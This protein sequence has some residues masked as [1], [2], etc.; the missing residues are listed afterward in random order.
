MRRLTHGDDRSPVAGHCR[1]CAPRMDYTGSVVDSFR[2]PTSRY[3]RCMRRRLRSAARAC[4][5]VIV[6]STALVHAAGDVRAE[7]TSDALARIRRDIATTQRDADRLTREYADSETRLGALDD[8]IAT[9]NRLVRDLEQQAQRWTSA[10]RLR[11]AELY[12]SG[13]RVS[14]EQ[15][16]DVT[17]TADAERAAVFGSSIAQRDQ[18]LIDRAVAT[19]RDLAAR[20]SSL[21]RARR[22]VASTTAA[23]ARA[24]ATLDGKLRRMAALERDLDLRLAAERRAAQRAAAAR[25]AAARAAARR[26]TSTTTSDS[27]APRP[28]PGSTATSPTT[29]APGPQ[30]D[31]PPVSNPPPAAGGYG[32]GTCPI[33][34]PVSFV[35]T[36]G[37]PRPGGRSHEGV[38]MMSPAGTPNVAVTSGRIVFNSGP[39]QGLGIFLYGDNGNSYWYFHLSAYA[40]SPRRVAAGEVIGYVGRTGNTQANHTHFEIHPGGGGAVNPYPAVRAVC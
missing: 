28:T 39:N 38:D 6:A 5:A 21:D 12:V 27:G 24:L 15:Q 20:R 35:D 23:Q 1:L 31:P 8:E 17:S 34:G 22:A 29:I 13:G 10:L 16:F 18:A 26:A 4:V 14:L 25:A 3:H 32:V 7:S 9:T 30:P 40:G 37:A 36:W 11:A 33:R 19:R 2:G